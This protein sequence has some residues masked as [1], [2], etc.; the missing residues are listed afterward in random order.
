MLEELQKDIRRDILDKIINDKNELEVLCET[1]DGEFVLGHT[2]NFLEVKIPNN[3]KIS[4]EFVKV[5]PYYTDGYYI[6][7]NII[8]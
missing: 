3:K 7:A 1:F 2:D 5:K 6:Y 4:N 8:K